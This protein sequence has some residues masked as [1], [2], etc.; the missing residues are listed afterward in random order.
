MSTRKMHD[1]IAKQARDIR[2]VGEPVSSDDARCHRVVTTLVRNLE[3]GVGQMP[4]FPWIVDTIMANTTYRSRDLVADLCDAFKSIATDALLGKTYTKTLATEP[5]RMDAMVRFFKGLKLSQDEVNRVIG[6]GICHMSE[7]AYTQAQTTETFVALGKALSWQLQMQKVPGLT[8]GAN[9]MSF[10]A[11][12]KCCEPSV[13]SQAAAT[14]EDRAMLLYSIT[15]TT[16]LMQ[17]VKSDE[18]RTKVFSSDL[19]L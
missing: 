17:S 12:V 11:L 14:G 15:G 7:F 3:Q 16:D 18:N 2:L 10:H 1:K 13:L 8:G 9:K 4:N 5:E 19:G 6:V